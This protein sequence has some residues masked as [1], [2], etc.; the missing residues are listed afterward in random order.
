[1]IELNDW[2]VR[3]KNETVGIV[4]APSFNFRRKKPKKQLK[5]NQGKKFKILINKCIT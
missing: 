2:F 1:M 5:I 4:C 3:L